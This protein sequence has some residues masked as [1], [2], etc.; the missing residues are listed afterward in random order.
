MSFLPIKPFGRNQPKL[1]ETERP[2]KFDK[3][4]LE[5]KFN[6]THVREPGEYEVPQY[7]TRYV[8]SKGEFFN[9]YGL[10]SQSIAL[11]VYPSKDMLPPLPPEMAPKRLYENA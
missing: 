8:N 11:N 3:P 1:T 2:R 7:F 10:G 4:G 9:G 6:M 5:Y